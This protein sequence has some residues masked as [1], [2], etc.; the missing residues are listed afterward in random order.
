MVTKYSCILR[1]QQ[2]EFQVSVTSLH[3][4]SLFSCKS[5]SP[6]LFQRCPLIEREVTAF[7]EILEEVGVIST[8]ILRAPSLLL[9]FSAAPC[10]VDL[11]ALPT[12]EKSRSPHPQL[13]LLQRMWELHSTAGLQQNASIQTAQTLKQLLL[14]LSC[15]ELIL[16]K[17]P[18]SISHSETW[19]KKDLGQTCVPVFKLHLY[20]TNMITLAH[21]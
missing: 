15:V 7:L 8:W 6:C 20:F 3:L 5:F 21:F 16:G 4:R 11:M 14:T 19:A 2:L 9:L 18:C 10:S 12:W 17:F 13:L 1:S